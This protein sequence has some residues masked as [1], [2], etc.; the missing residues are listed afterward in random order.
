MGRLPEES[1]VNGIAVAIGGGLPP[2]G[3]YDE[4]VIEP[5]RAIGRVALLAISARSAGIPDKYNMVSR[6]Y[7]FDLRPDTYDYPRPFMSQDD[8]P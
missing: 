8:G 1:Y 7:F 6:L 5:A 4:I 3:I 2:R